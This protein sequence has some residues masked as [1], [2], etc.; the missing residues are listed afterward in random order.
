MQPDLRVHLLLFFARHQ[1]TV[2][3]GLRE[4]G[5]RVAYMA[6]KEWRP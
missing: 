1:R 6:L 4:D 2:A 3:H 5:Q